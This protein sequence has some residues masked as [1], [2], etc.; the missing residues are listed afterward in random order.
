MKP[1]EVLLYNTGK[2]FYSYNNVILQTEVR[3]PFSLLH[4]LIECI[5]NNFSN[6]THILQWPATVS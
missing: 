5:R 4:K 1:F 3:D 6:Q 2:P